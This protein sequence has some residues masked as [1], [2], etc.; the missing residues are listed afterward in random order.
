MSVLTSLTFRQILPEHQIHQLKT[1]AFQEELLIIRNHQA[2]AQSVKK[3]LHN[4]TVFVRSGIVPFEVLELFNLS[5]LTHNGA[6]R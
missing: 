2:A 5:G 1:F 6:L 4:L 3:V